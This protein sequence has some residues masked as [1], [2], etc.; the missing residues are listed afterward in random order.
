MTQEGPRQRLGQQWEVDSVH[1]PVLLSGREQSISLVS[2]RS[3]TPLH[4][5]ERP[6]GEEIVFEGYLTDQHCYDNE[7]HMSISN[8]N[9]TLDRYPEKHTLSTMMEGRRCYQG[10][11]LLLESMPDPGE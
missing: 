9:T 8:P 5:S 10:S 1:E 6:D 4:N 7:N 2:R 3:G 11:W